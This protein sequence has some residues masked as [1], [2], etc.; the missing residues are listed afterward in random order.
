VHAGSPAAE[1]GIGRGDRIISVDG[2]AIL[3]GSPAALN[4]GLFPSEQAP[5]EFVIEKRDSG[6]LENVSLQAGS[7]ALEAVQNRSVIPTA[8]GNVGYLAFHDHIATSEKLLLDAMAYFSEQGVS[9]LVVDL[10]YN[11][12][13]YLDIASQFAFMV[14]GEQARNKTFEQL[15]F[16]SKHTS[17]NPVTG[18]PLQPILFHTTSLG[19]SAMPGQALPSL[20]LDRVFVLTSSGTCSASEAFVNGLRGIGVEVIMMG[21]TTCGKPYGFYPTPNCGSTYFSV[22]FKGVNAVGY[23]DYS[24]GFSPSEVP[25][26][27]RPDQVLGCTV[28]DD[29][30]YDLGDP[31]EGRLAAALYYR[32]FGSCPSV[33]AGAAAMTRSIPSYE[34]IR[35]PGREVKV[36][37]TR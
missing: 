11:G 14:A 37:S 32:D 17:T 7:V 34:I 21:G 29:L 30:N 4:A 23:G 10:R 12:G 25:A 5:H 1:A 31:L 35:T 2:T 16:N 28:P 18:R 24:D 33:P 20:G 19:F 9:D 6:S 13:G 22:Q 3:D 15:Q 26:P 8:T 36:M 27:E